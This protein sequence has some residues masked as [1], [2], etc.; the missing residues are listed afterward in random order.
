MKTSSACFRK[1]KLHSSHLRHDFWTAVI[2]FVTVPFL[3]KGEKPLP[4][5]CCHN[6]NPIALQYGNVCSSLFFCHFW[7]IARQASARIVRHCWWISTPPLGTGSQRMAAWKRKHGSQVLLEH[8][9][10]DVKQ[11]IHPN[12]KGVEIEYFLQLLGSGWKFKKQNN[13][14]NAL[15][16]CWRLSMI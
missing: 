15:S 11:D 16:E 13:T 14:W 9:W 8:L 12:E 2:H 10:T 3:P 7:S 5:W 1:T 6:G 4:S